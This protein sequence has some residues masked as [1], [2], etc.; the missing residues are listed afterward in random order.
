MFDSKDILDSIRKAC[1]KDSKAYKVTE[2]YLKLT[3]G[4]LDD[5]G[6]ALAVS[7]IL[8]IEKELINWARKH[9][10]NGTAIMQPEEAALCLIDDLRNKNLLK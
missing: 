6:I 2:Y 1:D 8:S 7:K 10:N 4:S 3:S 5:G 9:P